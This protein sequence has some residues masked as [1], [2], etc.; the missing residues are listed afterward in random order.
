MK[1]HLTKE[2]GTLMAQEIT[3]ETNDA[4]LEL[5]DPG[6]PMLSSS[7]LTV[8]RIFLHFIVDN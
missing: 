2:G 5:L 1:P 8:E 7:S 6:R 3:G 4:S